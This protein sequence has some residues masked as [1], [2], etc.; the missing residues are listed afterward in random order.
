MKIAKVTLIILVLLS[1]TY[2]IYMYSLSHGSCI[3]VLT[4]AT[5]R[6][7]GNTKI[8]GNPCQIP[9]WFRNIESYNL[10]DEN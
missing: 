2:S 9:F 6:I 10:G 4:Q 1:V 3:Q 5:N 8:F 7:T